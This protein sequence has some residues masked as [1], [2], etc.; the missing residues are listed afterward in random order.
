MARGERGINLLDEACRSHDIAYSQS[1]SLADRHKADSILENRAWERVKSRD[2]SIGEKAAAWGV[3]TAMKVKQKMGMGCA[4]EKKKT[5]RSKGMKK[6]KSSSGGKLSFRQHVLQPVLK[7]L[8]EIVKDEKI[9]SGVN[10]RKN[11]RQF[12]TK[13]LKIARSAV[14]K[15]GGRKKIRVPRIIPF[16]RSK[17]GG[18]LPLIPLFAGLSALGSI[19]GGA[20]A[21]A[22]AVVNSKNARKKLEED[23]RHNIVMEEIGK[24]GS[25]L[26]LRKTPKSG[27]GLFLK[28]QKNYH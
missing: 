1:N 26:Y 17:V 4:T 19:A 5:K 15:A 12:A 16:E 18:F 20:S 9:G 8:T 7:A 10:D 22:N 23:R 24:K 3:T 28:K 6:R 11:L 27:V 14:R 13:A 2:A 25:G 21:V